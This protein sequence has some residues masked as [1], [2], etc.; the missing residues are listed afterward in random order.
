MVYK[1]ILV[2]KSTESVIE[3]K[4]VDILTLSLLATADIR[5]GLS[6]VGPLLLTKCML[7]M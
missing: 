5:L 6:C 1:I 3:N 2:N 4:N 7:Q